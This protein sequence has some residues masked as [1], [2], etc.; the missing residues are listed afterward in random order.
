MMLT[1]DFFLSLKRFGRHSINILFHGYRLL[2]LLPL[3]IKERYIEHKSLGSLVQQRLSFGN[4][5]FL[6]HRYRINLFKAESN[7]FKSVLDVKIMNIKVRYF[8]TLRELVGTREDGLELMD[9]SNLAELLETISIKYGT[10]AFT[11]L[12]VTESG[13]IDPSIKFLINGVG[14]QSL[15]GLETELKDGDVVAIIPPIG[16]G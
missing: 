13:I 1:I 6:K 16:G 4:N 12:H 5:N 2:S 10:T 8:T 11:Y 9:G 3:G 7:R 14:A 15:R